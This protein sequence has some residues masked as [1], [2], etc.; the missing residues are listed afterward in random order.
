MW[1]WF[2]PHIEL[3]FPS[4]WVWQWG[5]NRINT[6]SCGMVAWYQPKWNWT[7][8]LART[9]FPWHFPDTSSVTSVPPTVWPGHLVPSPRKGKCVWNSEINTWDVYMDSQVVLHIHYL[10]FSSSFS[11]IHL[12]S[13]LPFSCSWLPLVDFEVGRG[14]LLD[15]GGGTAAGWAG[16]LYGLWAT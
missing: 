2:F 5:N 6:R 13:V 10:L 4:N 1:G 14:C 3:D 7:K 8:K 16:L 11:H 9:L 12:S 15:V